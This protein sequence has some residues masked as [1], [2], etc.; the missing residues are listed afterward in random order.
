MFQFF[1]ILFFFICIFYTNIHHASEIQ[2]Y[3]D[4]ISY[5][6]EKN[7]IAKG[8]A[9]IIYDKQIIIS[10][11][12]IFNK[13]NNKYILPLDFS[14]KDQKGNYYYG[15]SGEFSKD[16]K[17]AKINDIKLLLNDGSRIVGKSGLRNNQIDIIS[18]GSYSPCISR[19]QIKNFICPIWQLDGEKILHDNDKLF[20]Y[21]KHAKMKV[22]NIP[23]F[24]LPYLVSPSPLRKERK[25]GFLTPSM[26]FNFINTKVTQSNS[27]PYYFNIDIDKE[28]TFTPVFNYGGGVDSS[29]RFLFDYNQLL[30][31]GN[32]GIDISADTTFERQ[33]NNHWIK[34]ASIIT[35]YKQNLNEKFK[36]SINSEFQT[37]Q[38]YLNITDPNNE[39]NYKTSLSSTLNLHGYN[40]HKFNDQLLLNISSYQITKSDED[41]KTTPTA[42]PYI[43][44][45]SGIN[46]YKN[47][48]YENSYQFYN[49][50]RDIS[51]TD[52]A[53]KQK[54]IS[55]M[56]N[57]QRTFYDF[58]S[59]LILKTELHNQYYQTENK[60]IGSKDVSND[61]YRIYP[62]S[63]LF[64]ET[65]MK[66]KNSD[67]FINPKIFFILNSGQ[68]NS[69]RISNE[70]STNNISSISNESKLNRYS[71]T[72][73][74]DNSKRL[75]YGFNITKNKIQ[76]NFLQSYE[77]TKNSNYQK[78]N[79]NDD[80]L[81]DALADISYSSEKNNLKYEIRYDPDYNMLKTQYLSIT[82]NNLLGT[83]KASYLN[84]KKET[85]S[86]LSDANENIKIGFESK[87]FMKFSKVKFDGFYDL[88]EDKPNEY[89][90]AYSYFDECFG[91]N[92]DLKR[93]FYKDGDL[94]PQDMLT[95]MFSFKNLGSYKSTNLAVSETDKQDIQWESGSID[96]DLFK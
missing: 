8:N 44:Y 83:I 48:N 51:T 40:L 77:F 36:L 57:T 67:L 64:I 12:V 15:S 87:K 52:H 69:D 9:K 45:K 39:I 68:S 25:S 71:G 33:N 32:L 49:I 96:S 17:H 81:S 35:N 53:Q 80:Y 28:L 10:D 20:L 74:L 34:D 31:G 13:K 26:N 18:K 72:D 47:I 11:L 82:N 55:H 14:F 86:I 50:F 41:N 30:S 29:Q 84:E 5:D 91:I 3:A 6:S 46:Y 60:K 56:I 62:M 78:E 21:Q 38:T 95:L 70:E 79:G 73:K 2:L 27:F 23:V 19:I 54:K 90:V 85:N 65:P 42:L 89:N 75:S 63:G 7:L 4:S 22:F 76:L 24:Y 66:L 59:K 1:K 92:L 61:Y 16:L 94:E 58:K 37:S 43:S 93:S 88:I